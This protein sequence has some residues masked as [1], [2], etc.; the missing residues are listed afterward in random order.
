[1]YPPDKIEIPPNYLPEHPF[2]QGDNR[3]RDEVLAPFPRTKEDV[4]THLSEGLRE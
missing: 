3:L 2:D 4:Q 1:M